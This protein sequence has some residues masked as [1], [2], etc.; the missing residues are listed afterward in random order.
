MINK[1]FFFLEKTKKRIFSIE[2]FC[3]DLQNQEKILLTLDFDCKP[4]KVITREAE[5]LQIIKASKW[6][7][8]WKEKIHN[9]QLD[10]SKVLFS[11]KNNL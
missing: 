8:E 4:Q 6:K 2:K 9:Q 1:T 7:V 11:D 5:C 3:F 10:A